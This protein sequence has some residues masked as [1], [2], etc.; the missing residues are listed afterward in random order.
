MRAV[1]GAWYTT[2]FVPLGEL[3][4]LWTIGELDALCPMGYLVY[5]ALWV[6]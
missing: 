5:I 1:R 4:A 3:D 6:T 2:V